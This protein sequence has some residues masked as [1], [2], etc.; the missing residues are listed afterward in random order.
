[1]SDAATARPARRPARSGGG[2]PA[3]VLAV[4][5]ITGDPRAAGREDLLVSAGVPSRVW[6]ARVRLRERFC[7][8]P[9]LAVILPDLTAAAR[10]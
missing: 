3:D 7:Q 9:V 4:F 2:Q 10:A 8:R 1:M 5:G 6:P